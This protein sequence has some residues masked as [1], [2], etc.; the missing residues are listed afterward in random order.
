VLVVQAGAV[1]GNPFSG[2]DMMNMLIYPPA[3]P[4]PS[5]YM[6]YVNQRKGDIVTFMD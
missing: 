2:V 5:S 4:P 6:F 3:C 1:A